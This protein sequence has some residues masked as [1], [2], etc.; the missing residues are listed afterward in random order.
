MGFLI[1]FITISTAVTIS[2]LVCTSL[3]DKFSNNYWI[4]ALIMLGVIFILAS[5]CTI[6]DMIRRYKMVEKPTEQILEATQKITNGDFE[7][8]L[9]KSHS[10]DK[11]DNYDK[12]K[13]NLNIMAEEL[14]K[15]EILKSDFIANVSHEIKTPLSIIQNYATALQNKNLDEQTREKYSKTLITASKRLSNLISDI[16]KLSKLENQE[17]TDLMEVDVGELLRAC[18]ISFE[19]LF[20]K[21]NIE[22]NCN[23]DDIKILTSAVSLEIVF[24]NLISNAIKFT[25]NNGKIDISLKQNENFCILKVKDN[26]CGIDEKSGKHIFDKFYQGDT[27]HSGEGNGLG[28]ALVKKVVDNLG[29]GIS[30]ESELGVGSTFIVKVRKAKNE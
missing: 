18:V 25:E 19:E 27:S 7:I 2:I 28:L 1:L 4:I 29:G 13:D 21:K 22:L 8:K 11:F 15:N 6:I 5:I 3:L 30:V 12:I 17:I 20:D 24:N 10:Y 23:I 16:L 14:K 9:T 26:G